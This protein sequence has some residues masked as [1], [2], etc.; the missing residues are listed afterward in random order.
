[1]LGYFQ[2]SKNETTL[3]RELVAGLT[4]FST[5]AYIIVV[6][7]TL[8]SQTGMDFQAVTIATCLAAAIGCLLSGILSKYPFAQAPG[9]GLSAFFVYGVV[10]GG[11][12][13]WQGALAIVF[14]SG[15]IFII[16]TATGLRAAILDALP[17]GVRQAI[18]VG[19]GLFIALIGLNNAGVID[20]NQGPIIDI[21]LSG[22][23][24]SQADTIDKVLNA[25][26]QILEFGK[27]GDPIVY[28]TL[29]GLVLMVALSVWRVNGAILIGIVVITLVSIFANYSELPSNVTSSS[30]DISPVFLQLDFSAILGPDGF[31]TK[32]LFDIFFIVLAFTMVDLLDTVGTLYGTADK[33][34]FLDKDGKL[35]RVNGAL[36]ADAVATTA[37][38]LL[39]TSTTTTYIESGTGIAA[40]G[41]TGLTAIIV[42]LLFLATILFS[43]LV[44]LI[45]TSATSAAL[46]MVGILM[47]GAVSKIDFG[48]LDTTVPAFLTIVL[49]P[50]SYSIA[51][52]IGAGIITY[53]FIKAV[54]G[55]FKAVH[56]VAAIIA[57]LF[58]LRYAVI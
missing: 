50:F 55:D 6:S 53:V 17:I 32:A 23:G 28:L 7:P 13:T 57:I 38:S 16:L 41:K 49:M 42:G 43:P 25:P 21:L 19:I 35:P 37:G 2:L 47:I 56:P 14:I 45:P 10:I 31:S 51:N 5:M 20:V 54:K 11:G 26:P 52:G 39:G 9:I 4:T 58:V 29:L 3:G 27:F 48:E 34:G 1:M 12:Y 36:M 15:V 30:F 8:L 46:V 22:N 24:T 40:G 44:A 18:P 33:G